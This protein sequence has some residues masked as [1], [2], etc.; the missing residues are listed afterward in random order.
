MR[1]VP[2]IR[3]KIRGKIWQIVRI[4]KMP[5]DPHGECDAPYVKGKQIRIYGE[6]KGRELVDTV[7]HEALHAA[8][9]DLDD[10]AVHEVAH[11]LARLL[12]RAGLLRK[13]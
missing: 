7:L 4:Q 13:D 6:Q 5:G 9:W 1:G 10:E 12:D 8:F 2:W 3:A 11:D